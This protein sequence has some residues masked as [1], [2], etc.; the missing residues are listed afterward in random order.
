MSKYFKIIIIFLLASVAG[1]IIWRQFL[2]SGEVTVTVAK[3]STA[4]ETA[5]LLHRS[6]IISSPGLFVGA[7]ILSG[8]TQNIKAGTYVLTPRDS[9]LK[10]IKILTRGQSLVLK[11]TIPEGFTAR[12][13]AERL[14]SSGVADEKKFMDI[15]TQKNLEG[16]LFPQTYF[17]EP[18]SN[19]EKTAG[20]MVNEFNRNFN[21]DM[22]ARAKEMGMSERSV[23]I[24][25]SIIEKEAAVPR[26]RPHISGVFHNRLNRKWCLESCA[27]VL[28]ALGQHKAVIS[29]KDLK[30]DS[31]Y[32]TYRHYGLP[33]G[34]IGNPGL[35]SLKAALYPSDTDDM[36]FVVKSSG[37][38]A[39]SRYYRDHI[40]NKNIRRK[41]SRKS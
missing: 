2:P 29:Y 11:V 26:E 31:P 21:D 24:L 13:I 10:V 28:Y 15:V 20:A 22:R 39:F 32:N 1:F 23:V 41:S 18:G 17:F 8:N 3:G 37:T 6:N 12:Q 35:E 7:I 36:F 33:P 34:P 16:Y 5:A 4:K 38:H 30:I 25:A 27:T 14:A 40:N 19:E 9:I